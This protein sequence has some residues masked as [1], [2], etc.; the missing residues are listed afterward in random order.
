MRSQQAPNKLLR[1]LVV[2]VLCLGI[3]VD[4]IVG[5]LDLNSEAVG[6]RLFVELKRRSS[7]PRHHQDTITNLRAQGILAQLRV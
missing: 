1:L 4:V 2:L 5:A 3:R 6:L 7:T